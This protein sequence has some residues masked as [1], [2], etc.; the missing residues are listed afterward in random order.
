MLAEMIFIQGHAVQKVTVRDK[1]G[2]MG[3]LGYAISRV[4]TFY[5]FD[6]VILMIWGSN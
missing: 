2:G 5:V 1:M 3:G 6:C 4:L